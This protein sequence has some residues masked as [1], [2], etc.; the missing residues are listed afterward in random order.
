MRV[1]L[2]RFASALKTISFTRVD[3]PEPETPVTQTNFPIGNSTSM[4]LRL[5]I[6]APRTRE[7]APVVFGPLGGTAIRRCPE[8]NCPVTEPGV[9]STSS[10]GPCGD[11][12]AAVLACAGPHVD[13]PVGGAHHLLVVLDDEDGVAERAQPFERRDQAVVVALVQPDRRLVEDVE[14]ADELRADLGREPKPL[15]LAARERL[16]GAVELEIADTDIGQ[17]RQPLADLLHDP[18]SDQLLRR[19]QVELV[20]EAPAP[21]SPTCCVKS[22]IDLPP[23]FTASTAGLSRAPPHSGHGRKLMYSSIRSRCCWE[24]VSW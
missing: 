16:R 14:D 1:L 9:R 10:A 5:C 7:P 15:R 12:V 2:S 17:E 19:G 8:R 24:S 4:S 11:D 6:D 20:E 21:A 18:V 22:W 3:L 13:D 23:T